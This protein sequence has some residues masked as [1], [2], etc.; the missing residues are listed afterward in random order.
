MD[1]PKHSIIFTDSS[2]ELLT[3]ESM[4]E[5]G[6]LNII[7]LSKTHPTSKVQQEI[8][9][10]L[11]KYD[12]VYIFSKFPIDLS[13]DS[14]NLTLIS[15]NNYSH[16]VQ[17]YSLINKTIEQKN[18]Y[19]SI[20]ENIHHG[21]QVIDD[22]AVV[23]YVNP[24]FTNIT[25]IP[26]VERLNSN[27]KDFSPEGALY[28]SYLARKPII[29]LRSGGAGSKV[30]T[31]S[32][33]HPIIADNKFLG[34]VTTLQDISEIK[35]LTHKIL[36]DDNSIFL[37]DDTENLGFK[38]NYTFENLIGDSPQFRE[39]VELSKRIAK[40]KSTILITSES[41]TG[42]E[43]FAHAIHNES[44]FRNGPFITVNCA[45]IPENLLESELFGYEKG[46]F[47]SANRKKIGK[48]E[49]ANKGTIFLDEIGEMSLL[50]QAKLLRFLQ[51]R[52]IERIGGLTKINVDLRIIAATN[53]NLKEMVKFGEF[54][55]DLY[56]RL[57]VINIEIPPLRK[58]K[59]DI[60][61]ITEDLM[62]KISKRARLPKM[63]LTNKSYALLCEYDWPGN[64]REL[65][66]FLERV[67]NET[68]A[69]VI[70]KNLIEKN[71][72][73]LLQSN[74]QKH[75]VLETNEHLPLSIVEKSHIIKVLKQH[76][77]STLEGKKKVAKILGVSLATLYNKIKKY[78]IE[79]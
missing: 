67:M 16:Y 30:E 70:P 44:L 49:L 22:Q 11:K 65:E 52:E 61:S 17:I 77:H 63:Q 69:S 24:A 31:I 29:G 46:A 18:F 64:V 48:V 41:G 35:Y 5:L 36:D 56:Y 74:T 60:I 75:Y 39:V 72:S 6:L 51:S 33:A 23:K 3:F 53:K 34:A 28:K 20:L 58:R 2:E 32:N 12:S 19:F 47:T 73:R 62:D 26:A 37:T 57:N 76:D 15:G 59:S 40:S 42:K 27:I 68:T 45:A 21:I 9:D 7:Y 4:Q 50:L 10:V 71:I 54:R 25:N 66:N 8:S 78:N 13:D 55:E 38:A 43:L 1:K 79:Y 14:N